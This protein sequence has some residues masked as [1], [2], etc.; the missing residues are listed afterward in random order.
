MWQP[1][2]DEVQWKRPANKEKPTSGPH[3]D[4]DMNLR[5]AHN[6]IN[7][8]TP[9]LKRG[10]KIVI[11]GTH[12]LEN[13]VLMISWNPPRHLP[14]GNWA[15]PINLHQPNKSFSKSLEIVFND[16]VRKVEKF[17]KRYGQNTAILEES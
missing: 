8:V 10:M 5:M 4:Y 1:E 2:D 9:F 17:E 7:K 14:S 3:P 11:A 6:F 12:G 16:Y 13:S 15:N